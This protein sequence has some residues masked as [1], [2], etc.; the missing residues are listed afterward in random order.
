M[1]LEMS[2]CSLPSSE[3]TWSSLQTLFIEFSIFLPNYQGLKF[4][5]PSNRITDLPSSTSLETTSL[6]GM[7]P[8]IKEACHNII[9]D[10]NKTK[11]CPCSAHD[12]PMAAFSVNRDPSSY[13]SL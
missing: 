3:K 1:C 5:I 10:K 12:S 6:L 11:S 13:H 9:S 8:G 2:S 7:L 4:N